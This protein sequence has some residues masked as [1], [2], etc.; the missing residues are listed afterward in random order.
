MVDVF[1]IV[2]N[3]MEALLFFSPAYAPGPEN[4]HQ[5]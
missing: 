3:L 2:H 5:K 4:A 1:D